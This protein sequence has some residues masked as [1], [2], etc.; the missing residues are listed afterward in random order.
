MRIFIGNL[1]ILIFISVFSLL[2]MEM[3]K[4]LSST[5]SV[6]RVLEE[7]VELEDVRLSSNSLILDRHG[8]VISD[9]FTSENRISL[10]FKEIPT[11]VVNAFV[12]AEDQ[13]F[14]DHPGFDL[15]GIA[16]AFMVNVQSGSIEQ[17]GSTITQQLAR[18]LYLSHSQ[19]YERKLSELL[20]SYQIEREFSKEEI[21][22]LY[23]NSVYFSNGVYGIEAAA[24]Y[25][26]G[27]SAQDLSLAQT[28]FLCAVPNNPSHYNPLTGKEAVHER[29]AWI[30]QKMYEQGF[31]ENE[32]LETALEEEIVLHPFEKKDQYPDY[33]TYVL[34]ELEQLISNEEG[35]AQRLRTSSNNEERADITASLKARV[36]EVLASGIT[37]ETAL[38]PDIQAHTVST[39]NDHL[40]QTDIQGAVSVIDH[41]SSEIVALT[42][43]TSYNKFDFHRGFQAFRQPGSAIKPLLVF[44]P[45]LEETNAGINSIIDASPIKRGAYEPQNFGGAVYGKVPLETAFKHSYN[46]AAVRILDMVGVEE[47][48]SYLNKFDFSRVTSDDQR[49]PAALGGF[50][51]GM[52]VNEL[53]QAY[54]V[55]AAKGIYT[56]PKAIQTVKNAEGDILFEWAETG[57]EVWNEETINKMKKMME[58]VTSEGTGRTA[59]FN[60]QGY[61]GGK[62]GTTNDF[63]D[64]WFIG[65]SSQYT[66]GVWIGK[67]EPA[68]LYRESQNNL[69]TSLWREIMKG[70]H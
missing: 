61:I 37:I 69:H 22:E 47:S 60:T 59:R 58:K 19:N 63:Q 27:L 2:F 48:F 57:K 44:A 20:Y 41:H 49:L 54:T 43:G 10:P 30:L 9:V 1:F 36:Q 32:E 17:G 7:S 24:D 31:L 16:R 21:M 23:I 51:T 55:F 33:V 50:S 53:T 52:S 28:A 70:F 12:A 4:E 64:L 13:S 39:V 8:N 45:F 25:Y 35:Y 15:S 29:K 65:S 18:N 26:F 34:Y 5:Q 66:A 42:G 14:Y 38:A 3:A 40:S 11:P 68:S 56:S 67:D 6:H 62:T 46:T